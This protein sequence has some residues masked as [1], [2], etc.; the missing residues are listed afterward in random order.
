MAREAAMRIEWEYT[1]FR[2]GAY[3]GGPLRSDRDWG[4]ADPMNDAGGA[5][6]LLNARDAEGW[7]LVRVVRQDDPEA[8]GG[9]GYVAYMKRPVDASK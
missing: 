4:A 9:M 7:G 6:A 3:V 8:R 2:L 1:A 5:A